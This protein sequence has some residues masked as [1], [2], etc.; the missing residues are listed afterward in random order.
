MGRRA[1]H[2]GDLAKEIGATVLI[3]GDVVDV[4][5]PKLGLAQAIGEGLRRKPGPVLYAPEALLLRSCDKHA[6]AHERRSKVSV[7]R[8]ESEDDQGLFAV[9]RC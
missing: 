6:V 4:R 1:Q 9:E 7:E 8:V 2:V 3:D 5:E